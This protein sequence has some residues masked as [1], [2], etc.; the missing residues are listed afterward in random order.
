[1]VVS[2]LAMPLWA[3][4]PSAK[5]PPKEGEEE[6][7]L[8]PLVSRAVKEGYT[9]KGDKPIP[10]HG[11]YYRILKAQGKNAPGGAYGYVVKGKM[12]G[13]FAMVAYPAQLWCFGHHDLY[14]QS[15]WSG[16]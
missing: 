5:T 3:A 15:R 4:E 8:G 11:Y 13:G 12:I 9:K 10:Y 1:M 7:P 2:L 6:S 16:I 14:R